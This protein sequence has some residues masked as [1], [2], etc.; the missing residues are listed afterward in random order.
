MEGEEEYAKLM[1]P[2]RTALRAS[3][4]WPQREELEGKRNIRVTLHLFHRVVAAVIIVTLAMG[5]T[6]ETFTFWGEDMN[7]TIECSLVTSAFYL[8]VLRVL[9]LGLNRRPML[10][11]VDTMRT[12]WSTS[13]EQDRNL[14]RQRCS[15]AFKLSKFFIIC[16][17]FAGS[18]F[19][20]LPYLEVFTNSFFLPFN[21]H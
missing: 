10:Y 3:G 2:T 19:A 13:S 7:E 12:D 1:W 18:M 4:C 15:P 14:L 5:A 11:I 17:A 8:S 21:V 9:I 6:L 16:V 20:I